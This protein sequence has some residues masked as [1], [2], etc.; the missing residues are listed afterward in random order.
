MCCKILA[1]LSHSHDIMSRYCALS[2]HVMIC[3]LC[4]ICTM[5]IHNTCAALF[6][7]M[8]DVRTYYAC[9]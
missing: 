7:Y 4:A 3:T 6:K 8:H 5:Y 1:I 9:M 2:K